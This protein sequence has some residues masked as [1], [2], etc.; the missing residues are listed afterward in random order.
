MPSG[1]AHDV[2]LFPMNSER[3]IRDVIVPLISGKW[4][5]EGFAYERLE[6]TLFLIGKRGFAITAAHVV[7]QIQSNPD[8]AAVAF[9]NNAGEWVPV[10]IISFESHPDEDVAV[11]KLEQAPWPSW[12]TISATS[13]HQAC[14]YHAWGY[15][16]SIAESAAKYEEHGLERPDLVFTQGYVRRRISTPLPISIYR[17]TAFYE[18]SEQAGHGCSGG[19]VIS[20]SSVG[21]PLWSVCGVYI[22][23]LDGGFSASYCV[24]TDALHSWQPK[25]MGRSVRDESHDV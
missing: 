3:L 11:V 6:G 8:I 10:R 1:E 15:P 24:R 22:G 5:S 18:L 25:A 21:R 4:S 17:G 20:R 2:R 7:D 16:I 19:P 12:L 13:E 23:E 9:I 14:E